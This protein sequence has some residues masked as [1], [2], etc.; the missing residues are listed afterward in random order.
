MPTALAKRI[1][2]RARSDWQLVRRARLLALIFVV[3]GSLDIVST[4]AALAAGH[5]EGNPLIG[6]LQDSLG[7]W[8]ALP[9]YLFHVALAGLILW[10]P[11][12]RMLKTAVAVNLAYFAIVLNNFYIVG[13]PF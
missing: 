9:K 3:A 4:N 6:G 13:W 7:A 11:S 12:R 1:A 2:A 5:I 10:I 8:W